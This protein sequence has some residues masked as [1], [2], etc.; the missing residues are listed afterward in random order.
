MPVR[1]IVNC[2]SPTFFVLGEMLESVGSALFTVNVRPPDVPPPGVGLNTVTV[3]VPAESMSVTGM[4]AC[5]DDALTY[6]VTR[7][8]PSIRTTEP[9]TKF[10]PVMVIVN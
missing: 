8:S 3:D 9:E 5:S 4:V 1:F 7:F 6:V 10:D 2:G